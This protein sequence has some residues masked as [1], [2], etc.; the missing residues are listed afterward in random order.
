MEQVG[1]PAPRLR[2]LI[3]MLHQLRM[4]TNGATEW[5]LS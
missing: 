3:V 2:A 1:A 5:I 4:K